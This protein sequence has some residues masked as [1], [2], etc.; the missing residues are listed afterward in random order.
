M[1]KKLAEKI[2]ILS[3][4]PLFSHLN[5]A[6]ITF[7]AEIAREWDFPEGT[8]VISEGNQ[9]RSLF[10]VMDGKAS[11]TTFRNGQRIVLNSFR[12]GDCFGEMSFLDGEPRCTSVEMIE[13]GRVLE[14]DS[15]EF[16]DKVVS[17]PD[18]VLGITKKL[19]LKLR[20]ATDYIESLEFIMGHQDLHDAH[21]D[22]IKR[23][24]L[25]AECK[26]SNTCN[27]VIRVARYSL[28]IAEGLGFND[29]DVQTIRYAAPMHDIG[30]I[31]ISK[32]ILQ[33]PGK[34]TRE[35]FEIM[36]I[37]TT[38]GARILTQPK[39]DILKC[40]YDIA[41]CHHERFDGQG[42]PDGL[43]GEAI[44]VSARIV[45]IADVFDALVSSRPYKD[46]LTVE[47]AI[48]IIREERGKHFDPNITDIFIS[49]IDGV[50]KILEKFGQ[51]HAAS[52]FDINDF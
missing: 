50:R 46:A 32:S 33:K 18:F 9:T 14:I 45:G 22:T 42:Y 28:L 40:A 2:A 21:L 41:L 23:L 10:V 37:H 31:G 49:N 15:A 20:D 6:N 19:L 3:S 27:H 48:D 29:R 38:T 25:A 47:K 12:A 13:P 24:V 39:S 1:E 43:S 51:Q 34:L 44:P 4:I 5:A 16:R 30:K 11:A 35:E 17:N 36:K 26:D 7:L 8:E 52:L